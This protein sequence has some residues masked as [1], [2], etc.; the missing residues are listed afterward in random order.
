MAR[1]RIRIGR[2]EIEIESRDFYVDNQSLGRVIGEITK[3]IQANS[4]RI[5]ENSGGMV[6]DKAG[7]EP[8]L[9]YLESLDEAEVHE[10]EF[11]GPVKV[12]R[13]EIKSKL[14]VLENDSF[15]DRPRTVLETVDRM[16]EYGWITGALD[17]SKTLTSMAF[18]KE[19]T[20]DLQNNRSYYVK[21]APL[22]S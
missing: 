8:G 22:V 15:F 5:I 4:V 11:A 12:S 3:H 16:R 9:K 17:V 21:E 10:P 20:K 2:D 7:S 14:E 1:V 13:H 6:P 18:Q 19:L